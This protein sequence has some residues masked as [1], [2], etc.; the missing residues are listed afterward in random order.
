MSSQNKRFSR[1]LFRTKPEDGAL[2]ADVAEA[3]VPG[4]RGFVQ[5]L[6]RAKRD[7]L[8]GVS[9]LIEAQLDELEHIDSAIQDKSRRDSA[10]PAPKMSSRSPIPV[11]SLGEIMQKAGEVF[12]GKLRVSPGPV[13]PPPAKQSEAATPP[14]SAATAGERPKP[15]APEKI[16]IS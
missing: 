14:A 12:T 15:E 16:A 11:M 6:F 4:G 13:T 2:L 7:I 10:P 8:K 1:G 9:H 3:L 5:Q